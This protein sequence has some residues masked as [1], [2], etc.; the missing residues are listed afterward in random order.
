MLR[1]DAPFVDCCD[2]F[3]PFRAALGQNLANWADA[4]HTLTGAMFPVLGGAQAAE[5][6]SHKK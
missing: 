4:A 6:G 5:N 3:Y 2:L 1:A